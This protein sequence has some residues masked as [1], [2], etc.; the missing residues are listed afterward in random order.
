MDYGKILKRSVELTWHNKLLW[1][2]GILAALFTGGT[3]G[4]GQGMQ[5]S[6][7]QQDVDRFR[8]W[9]P[10]PGWQPPFQNLDWG[11]LAALGVGIILMLVLLMLVLAVL[12]VIVG[13]TSQGALVGAVDDLAAERRPTFREAIRRGWRRFLRL[14][15]QDV[16]IGAATFI[17]AMIVLIAYAVVAGMLLTPGI[18]MIVSKGSARGVG[19]AWVVLVGL[20]VALGLVLIIAAISAVQRVVQSY[21]QRASVLRLEGVFSAISSALKLLRS[22]PRESLLMWL[23]LALV[24]LGAGL[25]LLPVAVVMAIIVAAPVA[26]TYALSR[27]PLLAGLVAM[28]FAAVCGLVMLW[29]NGLLTAFR[30]TAWTLTYNE[31]TAAPAPAEPKPEALPAE[32]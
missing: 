11:R 29:V 8:R 12:S 23:W 5:Y 20:V 18:L 7:N 32:G 16:L 31:L 3:G 6:M 26:G 9:A 25:V 17:G 15:A 4:F 28:P 2:L 21:A 19:I 30:S 24:S 1:W 10:S 27:S 14:F 13:Y 22:K